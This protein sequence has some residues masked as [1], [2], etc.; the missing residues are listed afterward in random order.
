M[1]RNGAVE[2]LVK[3][4]Y[5]GV[6]LEF[7]NAIIEEISIRF[8]TIFPSGHNTFW[9]PA[10]NITLE[11]IRNFSRCFPNYMLNKYTQNIFSIYIG[12]PEHVNRVYLLK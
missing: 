9:V 4:N 8:G 6:K 1:S 3:L 12:L 2:M 7:K 11:Y 5:P 10:R